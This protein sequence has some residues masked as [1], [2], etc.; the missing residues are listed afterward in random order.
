MKVGCYTIQNAITFVYILILCI[1]H[2]MAWNEVL[3]W[4]EEALMINSL[5][6]SAIFFQLI[7]II[8]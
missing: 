2:I 8:F 4:L 1:F 7:E 5:K 6:M 3:E